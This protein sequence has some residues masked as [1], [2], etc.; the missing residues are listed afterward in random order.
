MEMGKH[1]SGSINLLHAPVIHDPGMNICRGRN[2]TALHAG[3]G[4]YYRNCCSED[5]HDLS[6]SLHYCHPQATG[7]PPQKRQ[8][9]LNMRFSNCNSFTAES[10][11]DGHN[12]AHKKKI[13][14]NNL[15]REKGCAYT[16][17]NSSVATQIASP[18][19]LALSKVSIK[20]SRFLSVAQSLLDEAVSIGK[21]VGPGPPG[22]WTQCFLPTP[23]NM[24]DNRPGG[25]T[26]CTMTDQLVVDRERI[27]ADCHHQCSSSRRK[28]LC[29]RIDKLL[30]LLDKVEK[31]YQEYNSSMKKVTTLFEDAAGSHAAKSYTSLAQDTVNGNFQCLRDAILAQIHATKGRLAAD[32][33]QCKN[34]ASKFCPIHLHIRQGRAPLHLDMSQSQQGWRQLRGLPE[35]SVAILRAWL[36]EHFLHPYPNDSAKLALAMQTGLTRNQVSNWFINARVRLWKPMIEEIYREEIEQAEADAYGHVEV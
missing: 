19:E 22:V 36:F 28:D 33:R 17:S 26:M 30:S 14:R 35:N 25:I 1:V 27:M 20:N 32:S 11:E 21:D 13:G 29:I 10:V 31:R 2:S 5:S 3:K 24:T 23:W 12:R 18:S 15:L 4:R 34:T 7:T 9:D 8:N 16:A 6:L